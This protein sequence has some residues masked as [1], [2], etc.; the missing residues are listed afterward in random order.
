MRRSAVLALT[1]LVGAAPIPA[2]EA[3]EFE[4]L[5]RTV[6]QAYDLPVLGV[7]GSEVWLARR[8]FGQSLTLSV[9]DLGELRRDRRRE[10]P[11]LARSGPVIWMTAHLHIEND[12][13]AWTTG[14]VRVDGRTVDAIDAIP[15]LADASLA[16]QMLY[17][18]VAVDGLADRVDLRIGRQIGVD[19]L[20][21]WAVDGIA[22]RVHL[23]WRLAV[24]AI[25]GARVR[26]ASPLGTGA[27]D[28]D[29][30]DGAD[31]REYVEGPTAG[32]GSWQIIDRSRAPSD[33]ALGVDSTYCPEREAWTPTVG[34]AIETERRQAISARLSYRR[35]QSRTPGLIGDVSRLDYPDTG[36]YPNESGQAPDWGVDEEHMALTGRG[37]WT[38]GSVAV[39]PWL[40]GRYSLLHAVLAE[41]G[42]GVRVARGAWSVEPEVG[43][44]VPTFDGD[45]LFN[46]FV[47]AAAT[48]LRVSARFAPRH[49][50]HGG[51]AVGWFRSY[52]LPA[53][54]TDP[55]A[56]WV[57][58]GRAGGE[59]AVTDRARARVDLVGDDGYGG[60][61]P[62]VTTALSWSATP[63]LRVSGR[64]GA[65]H[66][67]TDD[68]RDSTDGTRGV[69]QLG[70]DW[71]IAP[72]VMLHAQSEIADSPYAPRYARAMAVLDLAFEPEM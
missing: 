4:I 51:F 54:P 6:G 28:L 43:R 5:T 9:W 59:L 44:L 33:T 71:A 39:E 8:R 57:A 27:M 65:I 48:D 15:E 46:V 11:A 60:R 17:G 32:T 49:R 52:D 38:R 22:A 64:L 14:T 16:V 69:G 12:F 35:S 29:G 25:A 13:G 19:A 36:V 62:G 20:D 56:T 31:C 18:Y 55:R 61:R 50:R 58:G 63:R 42:A 47:V 72:G 3:Y 37:R 40:Q 26:A 7:L 70:A 66:L 24:S 30:T 2:A 34:V 23:P 45:S 68:Q 1:G 10:R 21:W 67:D 41:A 53:D